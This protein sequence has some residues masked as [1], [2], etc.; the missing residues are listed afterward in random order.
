MR[1]LDASILSAPL[2]LRVD[3]LGASP[4]QGGEG[5]TATTADGGTGAGGTQPAPEGGIGSFLLPMVF[6]LAIFWF[7]MIGPERK[8]RKKREAML[9]TLKK[10]DKVMT[11]S[12]IFG[13]IASVHDNIVSL[14]ISDNVRVRMSLQSVQGLEEAHGHDA[15]SGDKGGNKG[16]EKASQA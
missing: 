13:T 9:T 10:G 7:V 4:V 3:S 2:P 14:Q 6:I 12:G 11:T 1:A 15:A 5:E 8:N 16:G